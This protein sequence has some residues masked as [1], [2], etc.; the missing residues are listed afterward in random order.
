MKDLHLVKKLAREVAGLPPIP[1]GG[2]FGPSDSSVFDTNAD[3]PS[4][5]QYQIIAS[6]Y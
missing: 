5:Y 6:G 1:E 3:L 2:S 4:R